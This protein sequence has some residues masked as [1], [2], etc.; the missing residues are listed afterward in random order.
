MLH[1]GEPRAKKS[2]TTFLIAG[3]NGEFTE[4]SALTEVWVGYRWAVHKGGV[5]PR[6]AIRFSS[7]I[8]Y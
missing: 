8:S 3:N 5:L 1:R 4:M 6:T 2:D 7:C